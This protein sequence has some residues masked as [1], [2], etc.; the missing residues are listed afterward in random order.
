MTS[1]QF[2]KMLEST[3]KSLATHQLVPGIIRRPY[4]RG[5]PGFRLWSP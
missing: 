5:I 2:W 3:L 1:Q 4:H